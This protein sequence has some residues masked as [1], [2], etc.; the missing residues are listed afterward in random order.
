MG[1]RSWVS[2]SSLVS[3]Q[4]RVMR[5]NA[6]VALLL[7][8]GATMASPA[9]A[10]SQV[11]CPVV[12][13][14]LNRISKN[15][16]K[17]ILAMEKVAKKLDTSPLWIENCMRIYGR[18]VPRNVNI[19]Q[20]QREQ[21]LERM[22]EVELGPEDSAPEDVGAPEPFR[23]PE[24]ESAGTKKHKPNEYIRRHQYLPVGPPEPQD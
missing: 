2:V 24:A 1:F 11:A 8:G 12:I 6:S 22:E 20:D 10:V 18:P 14:E 7:I 5:K 23:E 3:L 19:D 21:I 17:P 15:E 4:N 9:F 16:D 13:S